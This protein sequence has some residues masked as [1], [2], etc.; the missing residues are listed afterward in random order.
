L[1]NGERGEKPKLR[2]VSGLNLL[3]ILE[4]LQKEG[5]KE[6]P[7][8]L[9]REKSTNDEWTVTHVREKKGKFTP[10]GWEER[11]EGAP[12]GNSTR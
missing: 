1:G 10:C 4:E 8:A 6:K 9:C 2:K 12:P 5:K 3:F 7:S 11:S